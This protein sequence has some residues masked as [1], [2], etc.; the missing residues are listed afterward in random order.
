MTALVFLFLT[1]SLSTSSYHRIIYIF[2]ITF[3]ILTLVLL[4]FAFLIF[5]SKWNRIHVQQ[6]TVVQLVSG[7][8]E[9][10]NPPPHGATAPSG[11]GPLYLRGFTITLNTTVGRTPLDEWLARR[12]D[13]Y[14]TTHNTYKRQA[15]MVM[16]GFETAI[17]ASE[18]SQSHALDRAATGTGWI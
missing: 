13:L 9:C 14:L 16:T 17:P 3:L 8:F 12:R 7:R 5:L 10:S 6:L 2:C 11:P 15:S 4:Y 1:F 18:Q